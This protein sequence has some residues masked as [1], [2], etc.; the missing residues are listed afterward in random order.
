MTETVE[1][2]IPV[3]ADAAEALASPARRAAAGHYLSAVLREG[4]I[5]ELM[6][7]AIA[8]LKK[9]ARA[10]GLTDDEIE[11]ELQAWRSERRG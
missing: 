1:V 6:A 4:R 2:A 3:D 9:E 5:G 8:D 7:E 11:A 10:A